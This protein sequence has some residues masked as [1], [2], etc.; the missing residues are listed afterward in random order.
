LRGSAKLSRYV[1]YVGGVGSAEL[2]NTHFSHVRLAVYPAFFACYTV[3]GTQKR[4]FCIPT[5]SAGG[6]GTECYADPVIYY[7]GQMP[8]GHSK[9]DSEDEMNQSLEDRCPSGMYPTLV[10]ILAKARYCLKI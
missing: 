1:Q 8:D 9:L 7:V 3:N 10:I 4:G 6:L 2:Y 5:S